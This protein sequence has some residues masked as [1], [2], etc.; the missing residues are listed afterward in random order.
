M[1]KKRKYKK[2]RTK[3]EIKQLI[4][5]A[6]M[7]LGNTSTLRIQNV[8]LNEDLDY[9]SPIHELLS[10]MR[11]PNYFSFTCRHLLNIELLPFQVVILRE[12]WNRKFPML[13]ASRGGSKTWL[14]SLYALLRALFH[15][16]SKIVV[17]GAAFRQSKLMFEYMEDFWKNA[18]ILRNMVGTGRHEGPKKDVDRC[19]FYVG[20]S[21]VIAIPLGDGSKIRGL[22]AN[23]VLADE[24]ASI[25]QETFE[26]VV[27][28]FGSVTASP[29]ERV[30]DVSKIGELRRL[31]FDVEADLR[32]GELGFGNQTVISGTAYYSFNHFYDYYIRYKQIIES[33]GDPQRLIE[34]FQGKVPDGFDWKDYSVFQIPWMSL[35]SGFMD[36]TQIAQAKATFHLSNYLMEYG[37]CFATDSNGFFKRSLIESCVTKHPIMMPISGSTQFSAVTAGSP[38]CKYIYGIDPASEQDN[39]SIVILEVWPDH[40]RIVYC[41]SANRQSLREQM[42]RAGK[43]TQK[44]FYNHCARKIRDL[45]KVFPTSHISMDAQGGGIH[46]MEALHDVDQMEDGEMPLWPWVKQ[47]DE[48][49]F[50]WEEKDKPTDGEPGLHILHL[51]QFAKADFTYEANHGLRKDFEDKVTLFPQFDSVTMELALQEDKLRHRE[52]DTLEDSVMEIEE[53][54]DELSTIQHDQTPSGRDRW[55]TP[56]VK[57]P[58]NKKGRLRKDRYSALLLGNIVARVMSHRLSGVQYQFAGGYVGQKSGAVSGRMYSGPDHIVSKMQGGHYGMGVRRG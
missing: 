50:W 51:C 1:V 10:V 58:G 9:E 23:Y 32:E 56:E 46:I 2:K 31:G 22:R 30:R 54:K 17:V 33:Q 48:D 28:G 53:L 38:N 24:F 6:Y 12:L 4:D 25:P 57:L 26:V 8:L 29:A 19:S 21:E 44:S 45:M 55:D 39:F 40:R 15:Q 34:I 14:L 27:R 37:A 5:E 52:F 47:G 36:E 18:P 3:E 7:G 43:P 49:V 41:W 16:G 20:S 13:I 11:N 35:P 42:Q